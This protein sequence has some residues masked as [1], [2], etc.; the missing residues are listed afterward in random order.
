[1][2]LSDVFIVS[3][4][5]N[6][7][8]KANITVYEWVD[9]VGANNDDI[10]GSLQLKFGDPDASKSPNDFR[11]VDPAAVQPEGDVACATDNGTAEVNPPWTAPDKDGGNLNPHEFFEGAVN[12]SDLGLDTCFSTAVANSRSSQEPGSTLHDFARMEFPTCNPS[13]TMQNTAAT[14]SPATLHAGET[15]T[16][17]FYD[18]N[19]GDIPLKIN[20][21]LLS[22][23]LHD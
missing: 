5:T 17:T 16:L 10:G 11:C 1:M 20:G 21:S 22:V 2:N 8:E 4:F 7:G 13:S 14:A 19:D 12:L 18:K 3:A 9:T 23:I 6:G 15:T